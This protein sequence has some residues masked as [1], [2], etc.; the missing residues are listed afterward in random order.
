MRQARLRRPVFRCCYGCEN[1]LLDLNDASDARAAFYACDYRGR[2]ISRTVYGAPNVTIRYAYD[3]DRI[4][5]EYDGAG[6]L[7]RKF[8]YGP[9]LDEPIC[10]IDVANGNAAYYYHFDGLGSVVAVPDAAH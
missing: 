5:A 6:T 9:G 10:L 8:V 2:R 7:L 4:L 1:C 3:G